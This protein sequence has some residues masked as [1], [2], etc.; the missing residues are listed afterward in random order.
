MTSSMM[1]T[2]GA[3]PHVGTAAFSPSLEQYALRL[4]ARRADIGGR[5]RAGAAQAAFV[6]NRISV[7]EL[8]FRA[9]VLLCKMK[10]KCSAVAF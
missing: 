2:R 5:F 9:H 8:R 3:A 4:L 6:A 7:C 1:K 10:S